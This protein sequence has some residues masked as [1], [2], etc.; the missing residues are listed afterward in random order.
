MLSLIFCANKVHGG[1]F[2]FV[3][4]APMFG[5]LK[6]MTTDEQIWDDFRK[7]KSYAL[8]HIYYQHVQFLFRCGKKFCKDDELVKDT[9]QDLFFDLIR[10]RKNLGKTD[11]IR[12]YLMASFRRKLGKAMKRKL[13]PAYNNDKKITAEIVYYNL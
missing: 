10:T 8:S 3:K 7:G 9:I 4:F 11:N 12:F 5:K 2:V 1:L 6:L 13:P